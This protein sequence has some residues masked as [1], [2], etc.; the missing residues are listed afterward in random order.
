[1]SDFT[2]SVV[3]GALFFRAPPLFLWVGFGD[4]SVPANAL[5]IDDQTYMG[6]GAITDLPS[7]QQLLNGA[8]DRGEFSLSGIVA[9]DQAP[10]LAAMAEADFSDL[11]NQPLNIGL[12][13]MDA[14]WTLTAA[15]RWL[16]DGTIDTLSITLGAVGD[17]GR[18]FTMTLGAGTATTGRSRADYAT[19]TD[20]QHQIEAPGDLILNHAPT[21]EK[22]KVWPGG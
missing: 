11:E 14:S 1:M 16:W 21:T 20:A 8:A 9:A 17:G 2:G 13:A 19:W 6:L 10:V 18:M 15:P 5:D 22:T 3:R 7:L 12:G 4:I